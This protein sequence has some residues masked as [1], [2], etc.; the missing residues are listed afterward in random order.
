MFSYLKYFDLFKAILFRF[1]KYIECHTIIYFLKLSLL[2]LI[3]QSH[4][5]NTHIHIKLIFVSNLN[6]LNLFE[7]DTKRFVMSGIAGQDPGSPLTLGASGT[8]P[9]LNDT[10]RQQFLDFCPELKMLYPSMHSPH[11]FG[12]EPNPLGC[13]R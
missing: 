11:C 2:Y 9:N 7:Q 13:F 6:L 12:A 1:Y 3:S 5:I 8:L 10:A 4:Q